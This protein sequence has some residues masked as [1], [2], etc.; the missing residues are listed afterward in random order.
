[1]EGAVPEPTGW[2][3]SAATGLVVGAP[4]AAAV[5]VLGYQADE[6]DLAIFLV[7]LEAPFVAVGLAVATYV[8]ISGLQWNWNDWWWTVEY[9]FVL[10]VVLP[11]GLATGGPS[12]STLERTV[13]W[14]AVALA[15]STGAALVAG[16]G[17][18]SSIRV[19]A[20]TVAMAA[21]PA[22]MRFDQASQ[23][24]WR[25]AELARGPTVLPV[26]A[27]YRPTAARA[28]D[29]SL[30]VDMTG[31]TWLVVWI[32]PCSTC[33]PGR[34]DHPFMLVVVVDGWHVSVTGPDE[35]VR[36][37]PAV[38]D[39]RLRRVSPAELARLPLGPKHTS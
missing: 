22:M 6:H 28:D 13:G 4:A 2:R 18:S 32:T 8:V 23:D 33:V 15:L 34:R 1:V 37:V 11:V 26:I 36:T 14:A 10:L 38:A 12:A 29:G 21:A 31:P 35:S 20:V 24:R 3:A 5:A 16:R 27:G 25:T 9:P 30:W 19:L 39:V 7:L 17:V